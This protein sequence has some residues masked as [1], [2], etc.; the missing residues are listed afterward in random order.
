M[1][2]IDSSFLDEGSGKIKRA[3]PRKRD[4]QPMAVIINFQPGSHI[5]CKRRE[6]NPSI[7]ARKAV[8][9]RNF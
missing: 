6:T 1:I 5:L 3:S 4:V 7:I 8:I 2:L 9:I